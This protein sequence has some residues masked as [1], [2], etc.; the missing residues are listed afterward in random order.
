MWWTPIQSKTWLHHLLWSNWTFSLGPFRPGWSVIIWLFYPC[1]IKCIW[2]TRVTWS[3]HQQAC[4][5]CTKKPH[6]ASVN[7]AVAQK[8]SKILQLKR[9]QNSI[10][11]CQW[12]LSS[13]CLYPCAPSVHNHYQKPTIFKIFL[14]ASYLQ[15][16]AGGLRDM[17]PSTRMILLLSH[18]QTL[19]PPSSCG[20]EASARWRTATADNFHWQLGIWHLIRFG[21]FFF[22]P[23]MPLPRSFTDLTVSQVEQ[24]PLPS[25]PAVGGDFAFFFLCS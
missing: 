17:N 7:A 16:W 2:W 1:R 9:F 21:H 11:V 20:A 10:K 25:I 24:N 4:R 8:P 15:A 23:R 5:V 12:P 13:H 19:S 3:Q 14:E 6:K 22:P 18:S